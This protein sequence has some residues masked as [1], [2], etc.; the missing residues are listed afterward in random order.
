LNCLSKEKGASRR[1]IDSRDNSHQSYTLAGNTP[2]PLLT[3]VLTPVLK[4]ESDS[5]AST[6]NRAVHQT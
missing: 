1:T 2:T 6:V 3:P 5:N 4:I